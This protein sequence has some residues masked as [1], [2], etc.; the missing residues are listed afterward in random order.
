[1]AAT[2]RK[3]LEIAVRLH[4]SEGSDSKRSDRAITTN[5]FPQEEVQ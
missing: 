5:W 4:L 2:S 1:M 3:V